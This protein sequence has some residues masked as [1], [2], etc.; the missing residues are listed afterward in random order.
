MTILLKTKKKTKKI[1]N[2]IKLNI[3]KK[4]TYNDYLSL[5]DG[6]FYQLING[7]L[8]MTASPSPLHQRISKTIEFLLVQYVEK[9]KKIGE[10]FHAPIDVYFEENEVYQP[11]IIFISNEK[12]AIIEDTKIN[13]APDLI[14]EILSPN[15]AYYDLKHKKKIYEKHGV[16]EYWIVDPVEKSMEIYE[17][18]NKKFNL[19]CD[20]DNS[21]KIKSK[22]LTE[23]D[24]N[25][26]EIF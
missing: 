22:L 19:I 21:K 5:N 14:V 11:D 17:N 26:M 24:F 20:T 4:Y 6:F 1:T 18:I 2:K 12:S 13:G 3:K 9:K 7:E 16:K 8:V 15:N 10:I 25:V 23:L